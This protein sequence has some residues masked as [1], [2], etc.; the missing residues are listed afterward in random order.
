MVKLMIR[1]VTP[2]LW[3]AVEDLFGRWGASNGCWCMYWRLGGAYRGK[4]EDNKE[5]LRKIV[6]RGPRRGCLL[7]TAICQWAGASSR[8]A[9]HSRGLTACGGSSVWT[10][11]L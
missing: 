7:S 5:K 4:R 11:C 1:P 6:K 3:L 8:R 9:M 2:D 10:I